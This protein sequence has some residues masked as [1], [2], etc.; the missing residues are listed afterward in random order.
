MHFLRAILALWRAGSRRHVCLWRIYPLQI[1]V[2][3]PLIFLQLRRI[4]DA[5]R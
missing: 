2:V 4:R 1:D 5:V 3:F